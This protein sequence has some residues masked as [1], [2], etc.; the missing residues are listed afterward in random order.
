MAQDLQKKLDD[1]VT[2]LGTAK[3]EV[4]NVARD[5]IL[6]RLAAK[7]PSLVLLDVRTEEERNTTIAGSIDVAG[8]WLALNEIDLKYWWCIPG[9]LR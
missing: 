7:D 9:T 1:V 3:F 6:K 8:E 5:E 4:P 2:S